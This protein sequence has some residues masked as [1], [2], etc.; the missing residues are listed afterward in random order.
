L[1]L[2]ILRLNHDWPHVV[3]QT[4]IHP[5]P[6]T[7]VFLTRHVRLYTLQNT[8]HLKLP[9]INPHNVTHCLMSQN[10]RERMFIVQI[11]FFIVMFLSLISQI[12][13]LMQTMKEVNPHPRIASCVNMR[14]V[15][16]LFVFFFFYATC[17]E[18]V[19]GRWNDLPASHEATSFFHIALNLGKVLFT[20]GS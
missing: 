5:R 2:S 14:S 11:S 19:Y 3:H 15:I 8:L 10:P 18:E 9:N 20:Y 6:I 4:Y 16:S 12:L 17:R 13:S 1:P 7:M